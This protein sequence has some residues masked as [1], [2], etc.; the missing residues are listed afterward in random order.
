MY[1]DSNVSTTGDIYTHVDHKDLDKN[2]SVLAK[3][4]GEICGRSVVEG[5][6]S[7]Q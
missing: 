7:V 4:F 3:A 2:A 6:K 5:S 1:S